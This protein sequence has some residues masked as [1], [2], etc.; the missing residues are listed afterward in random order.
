MGFQWGF[1]KGVVR[2]QYGFHKGFDQAFKFPIWFPPFSM[3]ARSW[4]RT[5]DGPARSQAN[6]LRDESVVE[7]QRDPEVFVG[8][9]FL[10]AWGAKA[11]KHTCSRN[12]C[13]L[14]L[15]AEGGKVKKQLFP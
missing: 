4:H 15:A 14:G 12:T 9:V 1:N 7:F 6:R 11:K 8:Q 3:P 10:E 2:P 13:L 5:Q